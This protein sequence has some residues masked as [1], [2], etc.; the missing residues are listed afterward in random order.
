MTLSLVV[1]V[2]ALFI[3]PSVG[4]GSDLRGDITQDGEIDGRDAL[5]ILRIVEGIETAVDEDVFAGDVFPSPGTNGR[6]IGDGQ[7]TREDAQQ[8][9]RH[10]VGLIPKGEITGQP[11]DS[12]PYIHEISPSHGP[13]GTEV[14][15]TGGNFFVSNE[16]SNAVFFGEI[17]TEILEVHGTRIVAVVP[18]D[19]QSGPIRVVNR[20]G[21]AISDGDFHVT[22]VKEYQLD[23]GSGVDTKDYGIWNAFQ[24]TDV[25][26]DRSFEIPVQQDDTTLIGAVP[27]GDSNN[28]FLLVQFPEDRTPVDSGLQLAAEEGDASVNALSTAKSLVFLCPFIVTSNSALGKQ[29]MELMD[30]VP[31]VHELAGVIEDRYPQTNEGID[32][33]QINAAWG[34]AVRA[35]LEAMPPSMLINRDGEIDHGRSAAGI[36]PSAMRL[37]HSPSVLAPGGLFQHRVPAHV[38]PA[39]AADDRQDSVPIHRITLDGDFINIKEPFDL[40]SGLRFRLNSNYSPLD[41]VIVLSQ[42]DVEDF[43]YG[44]NESAES[45]N[46][47]VFTRTGYSAATIANANLWTGKIDVAYNVVDYFSK[48]LRS[49]GNYMFP[50]VLNEFNDDRLLFNP[51]PEQAE[52]IYILR[53]YSGAIML[54][55]RFQHD[56]KM[57]GQIPVGREWA[58]F[59]RCE[60]IGQAVL[61]IWDLLTK[62]SKRWQRNAFRK[63]F[64]NALRMVTAY[65]SSFD[66]SRSYFEIVKMVLNIG[67]EYLKASFTTG[68]SGPLSGALGAKM[69]GFIE[70]LFENGS[71][72]L[73]FLDKVSSCG[74]IIE[75]SL[76]LFG[77]T[78]E[79]HFAIRPIR[80]EPYGP[81]PLESMLFVVGDPFKF[82][83]TGFSPTVGK[84]GTEV[85]VTGENF[86]SKK[87][88]NKIYVNGSQVRVTSVEGKE[89]LTF[90]MPEIKSYNRDRYFPVII[91]V[92]TSA[93]GERVEAPDRFQLIQFPTLK[94]VNP[95]AVFMP[96]SDAE[97]PWASRFQG[98][99]FDIMSDDLNLIENA[100]TARFYVFRR[101]VDEILAEEK[102]RVRARMPIVTSPGS[103]QSYGYD[104]ELYLEEPETGIESNRL[105]MRI[106]DKP[107]IESIEP[108]AVKAGQVVTVK[109]KNLAVPASPEEILPPIVTLEPDDPNSTRT[110]SANIIYHNMNR[111]IFRVDVSSV[112]EE[113]EAFSM[114]I[115]NPAGA[116]ET[117]TLNIQQGVMAFNTGYF[118]SMPSGYTIVLAAMPEK[119]DDTQGIKSNKHS[120]KS[121]EELVTGKSPNGVVSMQ[122]AMAILNGNLNPYKA[123]YD[124][125]NEKWY[126]ERK[127]QLET[128]T[129]EKGVT[130]YKYYFPETP[131]PPATGSFFKK[132]K[133]E[134]GNGPDHEYAEVY[135]YNIQHEDHGGDVTE[136][137]TGVRY[138]LDADPF[139]KEEGDYVVPI[140]G[141]PLIE[142]GTPYRDFSKGLRDR[143]VVTG[144]HTYDF[145]GTIE[146][147][148][149]DTIT[150]SQDAGTVQ[151]NN[152]T[153]EGDFTEYSFGTVKAR[154]PI[155]VNGNSAHIRS[156]TFHLTNGDLRIVNK[157]ACAIDSGFP[158]THLNGG[159]IFIQGGGGHKI[160]HLTIADSHGP[161]I[162][163]VDSNDNQIRA[164]IENSHS[165]GVELT[166]VSLSRVD[167]TIN[168]AEGT[169]VTLTGDCN[170]NTFYVRVSESLNGFVMDGGEFANTYIEGSMFDNNGYGLQLAGT[171]KNNQLMVKAYDNYQDGLRLEGKDSKENAITGQFYGNGGSGI[172]FKDGPHHNWIC[173]SSL[174]GNEQHGI[175]LIGEDTLFNEIFDTK[176]G[177]LKNDPAYP[178]GMPNKGW[179]IYVP[180]G[181]HNFIWHCALGG[182]T[183]GGLFLK[184]MTPSTDEI[185]QGWAA[186]DALF[187][188][189]S[190]DYVLVSD[191]TVGRAGFSDETYPKKSENTSGHGIHLENCSQVVLDQ[192]NVYGH[193]VGL[194]VGGTNSFGNL[195]NNFVSD[196]ANLDG[197]LV[198]DSIADE[199]NLVL[200]SGSKGNG[201]RLVNAQRTVFENPDFITNG[202]R[203]NELSAV[204]IDGALNVAVQCLEIVNSGKNAVEVLNSENTR[205]TACNISQCGADG[206][207]VSEQSINTTLDRI[208]LDQ[209]VGAGIYFDDVKNATLESPSEEWKGKYIS[210]RIEFNEGPGILLEDSVNIR[211][212]D[213][214]RGYKIYDNLNPGILIMGSNTQGV[215]V[216]SNSFLNNDTGIQ[217]EDGGDIVIGGQYGGGNRFSSN[218]RADIL[219]GGQ[220]SELTII[221]NDMQNSGLGSLE[222]VDVSPPSES[223]IVLENGI[224][225]AAIKSN[226]IK[227][228][229]SHGIQLRDGATETHISMN[230]ISDN[231]GH[232]IAVEGPATR[233]NRITANSI[234]NNAG[235]GIKLNGANNSIEPPVVRK[236]S[237]NGENISGVIQNA[238]VG[239][240]IEVYSDVD[241]EG[242]ILLGSTPVWGTEFFIS[243]FAGADV[244]LHGIV[245]HPD[246]NTSEFGGSQVFVS[247]PSDPIV[248]RSTVFGNQDIYLKERRNKSP[249]RL[250]EDEAAD[251]D[252]VFS[253][254]AKQVAFVS[255]RSGNSDIWTMKNNGGEQKPLTTDISADY[256]PDWSPK[257]GRILF[258]SE[259]DGNPEIYAQNAVGN[260]VITQTNDTFLY[261]S[262]KRTGE[263]WGVDFE[264]TSGALNAIQFYVEN[265]AEFEWQIL[266]WEEDRPGEILGSGTASPTD[267]GWYSVPLESFSVPERFLVGLI[268]L[269]DNQPTLGIA[270]N[271]NEG[272]HWQYNQF[273]ESW[274]PYTGALMIRAVPASAPPIRLT[275]NPAQDRYPAVSPDGQEIAFASGDENALS[276]WIMDIDGNNPQQ[277]TQND[278]SNYK[279]A[280]SID[281]KWIAFVSNRDGDEELYRINVDGTNEARLTN[282][283][284]HDTD[285][286]CDRSGNYLLFT[287][288]RND[289][290][291]IYSIRFGSSNASRLTY[292]DNESSQADISPVRLNS[293]EGQN[294]VNSIA[295]ARD[296]HDL[297]QKRTIA[298]ST[299]DAEISV[300][301]DSAAGPK[302]DTVT[303]PIRYDS[304]EELGNLAFQLQ[305]DPYLFDLVGTAVGSF[306]GELGMSAF[307][308]NDFEVG[309]GDYRLNAI[310]PLGQPGEESVVELVFKISSDADTSEAKIKF[311]NIEAYGIDY[312]EINAI[313]T[314]GTIEITDVETSIEG[315]MLY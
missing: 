57:I 295:A 152:T 76:G 11:S 230:E 238:P 164:D 91:E 265:P 72:L 31:E 8:I 252:P 181:N 105:D 296:D 298:Q 140:A 75:R 241:D 225:G 160:G 222:S 58:W 208:S 62:D 36:D 17:E 149:G 242:E 244:N 270:T 141:A 186:G 80:I 224:K 93:S 179:G 262:R 215:D 207:L 315:W 237:G 94:S 302:G 223:A 1:S 254:D 43:P 39:N 10:T 113:T 172:L 313:L 301:I 216:Y 112:T 26:E 65:S 128:V 194:Y 69:K 85:T 73:G 64:K 92:E 212:G 90:V 44:I 108:T 312:E 103:S 47:R 297:R 166:N 286:V 55:D 249:L 119:D 239:S 228:C 187:D 294:T 314:N 227:N 299:P 95:S 173:N 263:G 81:S 125:R 150:V 46:N 196:T 290:P 24:E 205:V 51:H 30:S 41:W 60:N 167:G 120:V 38:R 304:A 49:A 78:I 271:G 189:Y 82:E 54:Y 199:F 71:G 235:Q 214:S 195:I 245:I 257:G 40:N 159:G 83:V 67:V 9:L 300:V 27:K 16:R 70:T 162:K 56:A 165:H 28:L 259:R 310:H 307:Y 88:L 266:S 158:G 202:F 184:D 204:V 48:S 53:S 109:G 74:R 273:S 2:V 127:E 170:D 288:D 193:D 168:G 303:L 229:Q 145:S 188:R 23:V 100:P 279:P 66:E 107:V 132:D 136:T 201:A 203:S 258:V 148:P 260:A 20:G 138:D 7:L 197:I 171:I 139:H 118:P 86:M 79:V 276:I 161:S 126:V 115:W 102:K 98:T 176:F 178:S 309:N 135:Y 50:E 281:G 29:L 68:P 99:E 133:Q 191:L 32:D 221:G 213:S 155:Q 174:N 278:G 42:V 231:A 117:K 131:I 142:D 130:T 156:G 163:V 137:H 236:V 77:K 121:S 6:S 18:A 306:V 190:G 101:E 5:K 147:G 246:G 292:S 248:F 234:T 251:Y 123:P 19:A 185:N 220:V 169:G 243:A 275:N 4:H 122:E 182:N 153:L 209:A 305:Y 144:P 177:N 291:E 255:E 22:V 34:A 308:P 287:S 200:V 129:N 264:T 282:N 14:T 247:S 267:V 84:P 217:V 21:E 283:S 232:G 134:D 12:V 106:L 180:D 175:A 233:Y 274:Q 37:F 33:P 124:D 277:L 211:I 45:L 206:I 111:L 97:N 52:G 15:I 13:V 253:P 268:C 61:D 104:A 59:A 293:I 96:V 219:A 151:M 261:S 143:I 280:W 256:E 269:E 89:K 198:K 210:P 35:V 284:V 226:T 157:Y 311:V 192:I 116:S 285:P 250:T 146:L 289:I 25:K 218:R 272:H 3:I 63:G 110:A 154:G 114:K 183:L 87:E 240:I